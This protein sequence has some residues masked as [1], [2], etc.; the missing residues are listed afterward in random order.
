MGIQGREGLNSKLLLLIRKIYV[1]P[2]SEWAQDSTWRTGSSWKT[3]DHS[4]SE[5][6]RRFGK[7]KTHVEEASPSSQ[8]FRVQA[9]LHEAQV[10]PVRDM[11]GWTSRDAQRHG[12]KSVQAGRVSLFYSNARRGFLFIFWDNFF[13]Y[14]TISKTKLPLIN[15]VSKC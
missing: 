2:V 5:S 15:L 4:C 13:S 7:H 8:A 3:R 12:L 10:K 9:R 14:F 1:N 11:S 6:S